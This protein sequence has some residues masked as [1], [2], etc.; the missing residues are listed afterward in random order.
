MK[1]PRP[2]KSLELGFDHKK[3]QYFLRLSDKDLFPLEL[4]LPGNLRRIL[5]YKEQGKKGPVVFVNSEGKRA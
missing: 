2:S 3:E 1:E 4:I 5:V